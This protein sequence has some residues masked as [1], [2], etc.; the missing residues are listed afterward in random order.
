M[1]ACVFCNIVR[2]ITPARHVL[3]NEL[4]ACVAFHS[5]RPEAPVHVVVIPQVH[6]ERG[7]AANALPT[8]I[9]EAVRVAHTLGLTEPG[10]RLVINLGPDAGQRVEHLHIHVLGG[11]ESGTISG[12]PPVQ[13]AP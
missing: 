7:H 13:A 11:T 10:Y 9:R 3:T 6:L 1:N 12:I 8:I 2:G 4:I 5:A